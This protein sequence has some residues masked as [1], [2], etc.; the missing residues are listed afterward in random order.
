MSI[1]NINVPAGI[2]IVSV[3]TLSTSSK[4][5][6]LPASSTNQGRYLLIKD[7]YGNAQ[8]NNIQISTQG[9]DRID[10][11]LIRYPFSTNWGTMSLLAD[12]NISWTVSGFYN[13]SLTPAAPAGASLYPFVSHTFTNAGA[14]GRFGPTLNQCT[15]AYS[16]T[17]WASNPAYFNMTTQG[18]QLWTVPKTGVYTITCAGAGGGGATASFGCGRIVRT[19]VSLTAGSF[20]Q[21]VVGQQGVTNAGTQSS[22]GGGGSFVASGTTPATGVC[23]VAA[24]GGGGFLNAGTS[25]YSGQ[26]G[27]ASTSGNNSSDG[28]GTGGTNGNGGTGSQGGWGGGGGGFL[29]NG[30]AGSQPAG[31][32]WGYSGL[33]TAFVNGAIGGDTATVAVGGFGGGAGTHGNT[34][35]GGGGGGYSGGGGSGQNVSGAT[36]G[37]G[38]SFPAGATDLGLNQNM[39]Y[40]TIVAP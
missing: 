30:T 20:L 36:G 14:T 4:V 17:T 10:G 32:G 35:G 27:S 11:R 7:A 15:S 28:T 13:G 34:G 40:V 12:G 37:G 8:S 38:G 22:G 26:N 6:L 18:Y 16:A 19:T 23:L 31:G 5:V 24:G 33:G 2:S 9:F 25:S 21:I 29:T 1:Q 3:N 39:G